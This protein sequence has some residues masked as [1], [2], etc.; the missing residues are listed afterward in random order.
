MFYVDRCEDNI[1]GISADVFVGCLGYEDRATFIARKYKGSAGRKIAIG[2]NYN[3]VLGYEENRS[4]YVANGFLT[5][6]CG[7]E[8]FETL[9]REQIPLKE[10]TVLVVDVSSFSRYRIAAL[11]AFFAER[12]TIFNVVVHFVYAVAEFTEPM[13]WNAPVEQTS[14]I[15]HSFAGWPSDPGEP[16]SCILGLG[17]EEGKAIGA[18]EFL[19]AGPVWLF[20]PLGWDPRFVEWVDK[21][22]ED[23]IKQIP[24]GRVVDYSVARPL[25]LYRRLDSLARGLCARGRVALLPFGPKMFAVVALLVALGYRKELSVWRVTAGGYEEPVRRRATGDLCCITLVLGVGGGYPGQATN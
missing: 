4:W 24:G 20:R 16:L 23:L 2:F 15:H 12:E 25:V 7:D 17:Y 9:L 8:E 21:R 10:G 11:I 5:F 22:N 19:E 14:P 3:K 13:D 18:I 6:E 1:L